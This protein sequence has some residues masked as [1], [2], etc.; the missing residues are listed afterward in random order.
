M[1]FTSEEAALI[2]RLSVPKGWYHD[3]A[4]ALKVKIKAHLLAKTAHCCCYC[5]R[6][7]H[8]WHGLTIDIEH[9]LPKGRFP[10]HT[11]NITNLSVSCKRCNMGIKREDTSFYTGPAGANPFISVHYQIIH[12]NLDN[13]K[14]HL[15]FASAQVNDKSVIKYRVV[16]GSQ[17]GNE[18]YTYFKLKDVELN[19]FDEAQGL[20]VVSPSSTG[21]LIKML[22]EILD[23][24]AA[25]EAQG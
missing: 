25:L 24:E 2:A 6:S 18:T 13:P 22:D 15:L 11:F 4:D 10:Q 17:K 16:N 7:M 3:D 8:Q 9:V 12:P 20:S 21:A 5:R 19:T 14:A 1:I 23:A